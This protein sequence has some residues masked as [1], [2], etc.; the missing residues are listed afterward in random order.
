MAVPSAE[1]SHDSKCYVASASQGSWTMNR[2]FSLRPLLVRIAWGALL[3]V[4]QPALVDA[5]TK[6]VRAQAEHVHRH[7][8]SQKPD[9]TPAEKRRASINAWTVGLAGGL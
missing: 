5:Q 8:P 9:E 4:L 2:G 6:N 3:L 7:I 1:A